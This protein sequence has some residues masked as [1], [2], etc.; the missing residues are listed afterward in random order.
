MAADNDSLT[1]R[2]ADFL[3]NVTIPEHASEAA[4]TYL[5]R[6][7]NTDLAEMLGLA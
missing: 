6:T 4:R 2:F 5:E 7:G 1:L 3:E